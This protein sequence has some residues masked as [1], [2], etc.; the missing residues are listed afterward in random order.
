[1]PCVSEVEALRR[2]VR[3]KSSLQLFPLEKC[4]ANCLCNTLSLIVGI[5]LLVFLRKWNQPITCLLLSRIKSFNFSLLIRPVESCKRSIRGHVT[6]V[7]TSESGYSIFSRI[8][9]SN[10]NDNKNNIDN[11]NN[12]SSSSNSH[13]A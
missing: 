4:T 3:K 12:N 2:Q 1:V 8:N 10:K 6:M 7:S 13:K 11:N 5:K 9:C